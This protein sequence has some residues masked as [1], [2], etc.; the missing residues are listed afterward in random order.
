MKQLIVVLRYLTLIVMVDRYVI[1][2]REHLSK[3]NKAF[4]VIEDHLKDFIPYPKT[5]LWEIP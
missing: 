4:S 1:L 3:R 2:H 5:C